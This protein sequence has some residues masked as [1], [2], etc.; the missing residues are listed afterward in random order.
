MKFDKETQTLVYLP[1]RFDALAPFGAIHAVFR[2]ALELGLDDMLV[3]HP[4]F[5]FQGVEFEGPLRTKLATGFE[6][7]LPSLA[8]VKRRTM[9][10]RIARRVLR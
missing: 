5:F 8:A 4:E 3:R 7:L 1:K 6:E 9:A 2:G 10:L